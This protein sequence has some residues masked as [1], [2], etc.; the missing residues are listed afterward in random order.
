MQILDFAH[1]LPKEEFTFVEWINFVEANPQFLQTDSIAPITMAIN[2][3]IENIQEVLKPIDILREKL[4]RH[5]IIRCQKTEFAEIYAQCLASDN[6]E[7]VPAET[8]DPSLPTYVKY[9]QK[10]GDWILREKFRILV[11]IREIRVNINI[12]SLY[13]LYVRCGDVEGVGV[14]GDGNST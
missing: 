2:K 7:Y 5:I 12:V 13:M 11:L 14:W 6:F 1:A 8:N 10:Y 9:K 3:G 4:S